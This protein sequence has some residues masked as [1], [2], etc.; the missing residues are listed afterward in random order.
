MRDVDKTLVT[1]D[2]GN[3][4]E[5]GRSVSETLKWRLHERDW[6]TGDVFGVYI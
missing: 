6:M 3:P 2:L 1:C 4:L 5:T